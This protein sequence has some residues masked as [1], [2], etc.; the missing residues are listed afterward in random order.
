MFKPLPGG[1]SSIVAQMLDEIDR[2]YSTFLTR[3]VRNPRRDALRNKI[4][5]YF[6]LDSYEDNRPVLIACLDGFCLK[7]VEKSAVNAYFND[8]RHV[9]G[10]LVV[11]S[12]SRLKCGVREHVDMNKNLYVKNRLL[13]IDVRPIDHDLAST[14]DYALKAL[15]TG[16]ASWDDVAVFP[17]AM[18]EG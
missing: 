10:I 4:S 9:H 13:R 2:V 14:T 17:K 7:R 12:K 11:P 18:S 3:V 5:Q 15:K 16:R 6:G 8:G 1:L